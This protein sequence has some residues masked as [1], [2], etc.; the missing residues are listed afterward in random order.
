MV[1][2]AILIGSTAIDGV[3]YLVVGDVMVR[4]RCERIFADSRHRHQ[5]FEMRSANV[6]ARRKCTSE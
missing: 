1:D 6:I 4:Y 5:P 2:L 3:M